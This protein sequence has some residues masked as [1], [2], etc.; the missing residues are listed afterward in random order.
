MLLAADFA[1]DAAERI[2]EMLA[3]D[4]TR[5]GRTRRY[6]MVCA[7]LWDQ[8]VQ[9]VGSSRQVDV[10]LSC[11]DTPWWQMIR[12]A[13]AHRGRAPCRSTPGEPPR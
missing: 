11:P 6:P 8:L 9:V 3:L 1:W 2:D 7:V 12:R 5:G 13:A 10:E 4:P